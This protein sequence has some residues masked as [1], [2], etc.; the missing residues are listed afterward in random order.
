MN[1]LKTR[2]YSLN[3][4]FIISISL[5][6]LTSLFCF[7][8]A[9][10]IGYRVVAF[11][12]MLLVSILAILFEILPVLVAAL[13]SALIWNF[14]FIPPI[15][16]FH[17][18]E[19]EDTLMFLM[20]FVIALINAVLTHKIRENERIEQQKNEREKSI[21]L[22]NTLLNSLSHE[23]RTPIST[24]VGAI[25]TLNSSE[26]KLSKETQSILH[27]EI[28]T[29][30]L[31]L[32]RQVENLLSMSRLEAGM[33]KPKLDWCD[34]NELIFNIINNIQTEAIHHRIQFEPQD[35][36]PLCK[37]DHGFLEQ[38]IGNLVFNAIHHTPE[39]SLIKLNA[40]CQDGFCHIE[41]SD[42][43]LGF[44]THELTLV[45]DKFYRLNPGKTG[46]IGLGLSIVKGFTE[47]LNG[48]INLEN[49]K[50]GG[51]KFTVVLPVETSSYK[52]LE[53]E[54]S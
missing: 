25:D 21:Q 7:F 16:T 51:A 52:D 13:L 8:V 1:I 46:G 30:S 40:K 19:P 15:F 53:H 10:W 43:G 27:D 48:K 42:N 14:F 38:I 37:T 31:R 20:Y 3:Y 5:V 54:Q 50:N 17:I 11:I 49:G 12:L 24:I 35:E 32:N 45:F 39:N 28:E 18:G 41:I 23:L 2:K 6:I 22:Y 26:S 4:Q 34:V 33:L 44:P 36:M 29:A 47:A 9:H